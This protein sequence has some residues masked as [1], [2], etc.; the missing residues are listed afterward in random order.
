ERLET[1]SADRYDVLLEL[2]KRGVGDGEIRA[3]TGIDPWF[4]H[5]LRRP[6]DAF[7]GVRT[8]KAVDTCAAEFQAE[9]PYYYSAWER[10]ERESGVGRGER[11]GVMIVGSGPNGIGQGIEFDYCWVH[12]AMTVRG[13]GRDA[14]MVNCNPETVSPDYDTSD[15]LYFEPLT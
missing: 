7:E 14:V 10:G 6:G 2:Q 8:Y 13:S 1:P 5:E 12:A 9:T 11:P 3:R 4:L 15:R